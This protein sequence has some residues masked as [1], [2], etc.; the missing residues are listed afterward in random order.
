MSSETITLDLEDGHAKSLANLAY[1][2]ELGDQVLGRFLPRRLVFGVNLVPHGRPRRIE[3]RGHIVGSF[4]TQQP[5]QHVGE[6]EHR[7]GGHPPRVGE[8]GNGVVGAENVP[9]GVD[10]EEPRLLLAF[11]GHRAKLGSDWP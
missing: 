7:V 6:A 1:V 5:P 10:E 11:L 9:T 2:G 3:G 4:L 8:V